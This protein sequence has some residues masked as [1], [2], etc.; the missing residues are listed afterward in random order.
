MEI[1]RPGRAKNVARCTGNRAFGGKENG[2]LHEAIEIEYARQLA[3]VPSFTVMLHRCWSVGQVLSRQPIQLALVNENAFVYTCIK[4]EQSN[5]C[6]GIDLLSIVLIIAN[7]S[8][9]NFS[10]LQTFLF[11]NRLSALLS[12]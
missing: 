4:Y 10:V 1:G 7:R 12:L 9:N 3:S 8:L 6:M 2:Q 5:D 11:L